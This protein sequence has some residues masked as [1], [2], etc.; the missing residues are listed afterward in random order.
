M[1]SGG[2]PF[3]APQ[4]DTVAAKSRRLLYERARSDAHASALKNKSAVPAHVSWRNL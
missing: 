1:L 3:K 4:S 2:E